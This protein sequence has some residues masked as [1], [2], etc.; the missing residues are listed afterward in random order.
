MSSIVPSRLYR[1][2][3]FES[4]EVFQQQAGGWLR[5]SK[6]SDDILEQQA[7][8]VRVA[9]LGGDLLA[10]MLVGVVAIARKTHRRDDLLVARILLVVFRRS[11]LTPCR[12]DRHKEENSEKYA[13]RRHRK[14]RII[15]G[16][17]TAAE[18]RY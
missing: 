10:Q 9:H 16:W 1:I 17:P 13:G 4:H 7:A 14:P 11:V 6:E 12:E 15:A 3:I 8:V 18:G 2:K 5:I